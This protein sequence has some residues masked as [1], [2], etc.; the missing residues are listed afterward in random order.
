MQ[1]G[2]KV[3]LKLDKHTYNSTSAQNSKLRSTFMQ[4]TLFVK[5]FFRKHNLL[6]E[7]LKLYASKTKFGDIDSWGCISSIG[8]EWARSK[9][10]GVFL[11]GQETSWEGGQS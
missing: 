8:W 9:L 5:I 2:T 4:Y 7:T 3:A 1:S 6:Q 10:E 11:V